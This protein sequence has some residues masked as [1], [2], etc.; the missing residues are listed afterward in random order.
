MAPKG[1]TRKRALSTNKDV[2]TGVDVKRTRQSPRSMKNTGKSAKQS[3]KS[4]GKQSLKES[5]ESGDDYEITQSEDVGDESDYDV[6]GESED[7]QDNEDDSV[8]T[9]YSSEDESSNRRKSAT[10][11]GR[12]SGATPSRMK[13]KE[14]SSHDM[15]TGLGPG[16]VV[17]TKRPKAREAGGT[18]YTDDTVH[19]NTMLFLGDLA[20]NNRR[21]WLKSKSFIFIFTFIFIFKVWFVRNV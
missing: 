6:G 12:L 14:H 17:I 5:E 13:S 20:A 18:P 7:E 21:D 9:E 15:K 10:N 4:Q 3:T 8:P 16:T 2:K 19:P 11:G 1:T